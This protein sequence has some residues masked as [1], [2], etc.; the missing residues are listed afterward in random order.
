MCEYERLKDEKDDVLMMMTVWIGACVCPYMCKRCSTG[1]LMVMVMMV[2]V[3]IL[4]W[5]GE[6]EYAEL[7]PAEL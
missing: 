4:R 1:E 6:V 5:R 2:D 3:L 7:A